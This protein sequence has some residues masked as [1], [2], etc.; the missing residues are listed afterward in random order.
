[1]KKQ[2][3]ENKLLTMRCVQKKCLC[4]TCAPKSIHKENLEEILKIYNK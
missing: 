2:L 3:L 1:M 4:G